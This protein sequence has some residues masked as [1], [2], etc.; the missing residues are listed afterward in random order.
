MRKLHLWWGILFVGVF[1][2][3]G[4]YMRVRFPEAHR[5]DMGMRMMFRSAHVYILLSALLNMVLGAHLSP[6]EQGWRRVAERTAS[7]LLVASPAVF[8]AAFFIEPAPQRLDRPL[9]LAG[10][11]LAVL[12]TLLHTASAARRQR[13]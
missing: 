11:I 4:V 3:T 8:T 1:L 7:A 2:A 13:E 12:G 5:D 9:A 10:L 6:A